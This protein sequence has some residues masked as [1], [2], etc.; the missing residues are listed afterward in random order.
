MRRTEHS[1]LFAMP[2]SEEEVREGLDLNPAEISMGGTSWKLLV[3]LLV[4]RRKE[5]EHIE[6]LFN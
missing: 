2:W 6:S 5:V 4:K 1:H 3:K